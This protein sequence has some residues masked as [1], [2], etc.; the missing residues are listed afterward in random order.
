M[1]ETREA[2]D[3]FSIN[4]RS[5][6]H[7]F[8]NCTQ[9]TAEETDLIGDEVF[10]EVR[11]EFVI[12][13]TS[14]ASA[15]VTFLS[16]DELLCGTDELGP[17]KIIQTVDVSFKN[18][19]ENR[20]RNVR[21]HS[22]GYKVDE[23]ILASR[24]RP[25]N[26]SVTDGE[27]VLDYF[28]NETSADTDFH[29]KL[30]EVRDGMCVLDDGVH[31]LVRFNE[32]SQTI[33]SVELVRDEK[34]NETACQQFQRQIVRHLFNTLNLTSNYTQ[35]GFAS[36]IYVSKFWSPSYDVA[37]WAR[38]DVHNIP[39]WSTEMRETEKAVICSGIATSA[40]YS[41]F[42]S[43]VRSA[44]SRKYLNV[45]EGL[46]VEFGQVDEINFPLDSENQTAIVQLLIQVQF[47]N[48]YEKIQQSGAQIFFGNLLLILFC[49]L[50]LSFV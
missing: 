21:K 44:G 37:S 1:T 46:K 39:A 35:D 27:M 7:T 3:V 29:M 40:T 45:I 15:T 49:R 14:I 9:I 13:D 12:N 36:D 25:V 28:R 18:L 38:V 19:N 17:T 6:R 24:L 8:V 34:L 41:I 43:R 33:C 26:E 23:L 10:D 4:L 5:C 48:M 22:R 30:P 11:M 32:N 31:D 2:A 16:H 47:I 50:F 20:D 42:S